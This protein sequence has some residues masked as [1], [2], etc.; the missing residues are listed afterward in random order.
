MALVQFVATGRVPA[1]S[2][3][4]DPTAQDATP[5]HHWPP[6]PVPALRRPASVTTVAPNPSVS[7]SGC[8]AT[9]TISGQLVRSSSGAVPAHRA[10]PASVFRRSVNGRAANRAP[11]PH[12]R[13]SSR[14]SR[15]Q[16]QPLEIPLGVALPHIDA[17]GRRRARHAER[18]G[19]AAPAQSARPVRVMVSRRRFRP[20]RGCVA[21][22]TQPCPCGS[23]DRRRS[24][25]AHTSI[26]SPAAS[27]ASTA[28]RCARVCGSAESLGGTGIQRR[29]HGPRSAEPAR[30]DSD[31][32]VPEAGP[33]QVLARSADGH[34]GRTAELN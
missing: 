20:P 27:A 22:S 6:P 29:G 23:T 12:A 14:G 33:G 19:T 9:T 24:A 26:A 11:Y 2:R 4:N 3:S 8:A 34:R 1:G 21:R 5:R 16:A 30:R 13:A 7:S 18:P 15:Q 10:S 28:P 25:A 31:R 32:A 17:S